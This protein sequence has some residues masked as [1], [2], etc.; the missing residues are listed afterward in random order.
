[1]LAGLRERMIPAVLLNGRMSEKSFRN[2]YRFK[3]WAQQPS[4]STFVLSLDPN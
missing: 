3:G 1:M 4:S 2:W